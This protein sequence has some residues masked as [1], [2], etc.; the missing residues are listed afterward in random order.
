[1]EFRPLAAKV[2]A[3]G[4]SAKTALGNATVVYACA[5]AAATVTNVTSGATFHMG[6]NQALVFHKDKFDLIHASSANV[7]FTKIAFPR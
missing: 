6:A 5:T 2:V 4:D 3:N 7:H 1:M